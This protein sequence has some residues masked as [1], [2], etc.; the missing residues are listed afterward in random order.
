MEP[1][2]MSDSRVRPHLPF[3]FERVLLV[4]GVVV[5]WALRA[6]YWRGV[7]ELP[8]SDMADF[9]RIALRVLREW[10]FQ[11][12]AFWRSYKMPVLP[13]L[14]AGVWGVAGAHNYLAWRI[15]QTAITC[16]AMTWL[17]L[18]LRRVTG[19]RW[20][21]VAFV[22]VVALTRSSIFW[23]YKYATEGVAEALLYAVCAALL[24]ALRSRRPVAFV[25]TGV[26][27]TA[28]S[29]TKRA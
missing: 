15:F 14:G 1:S 6:L 10:S 4:A 28:A 16:L 17:A 29:L 21:G 5:F 27:L 23:S 25:L 2:L 11:H 12:D 13:L 26:L 8:F 7:D 9:E 20:V 18:E 22:W 3:T 24:W 19:A